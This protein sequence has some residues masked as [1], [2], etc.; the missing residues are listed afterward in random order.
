MTT[1]TP[2]RTIACPKCG[3][4]IDVS[5]L[6][7]RQIEEGLKKDFDARLA[8]EQKKYQE[9]AGE[10]EAAGRRIEEAQKRVDEAQQR[11][12]SDI[13][14]GVEQRIGAERRK[15]EE[16]IRKSLEEENSTRVKSMQEE[17]DKKSEQVKELHRTKSENERL[18]RE[19]DELKDS[20]EAELQK[21]MNDQLQDERAKIQKT[22]EDRVQMKLSEKDNLIEQMRH[23][24]QEAQRKAEQ[25]S[26]QMQG[27][28]QELAIEEWLRES[29]PLDTI[30]E[31]KKGARGADCLHIVN[32]RTR[33]NCGS[34]YYESKRTKDFQPAW[35]EKFKTDLRA[36][37]ATIGVIVTEAMP[38][39]MDRLGSNQRVWR[40]FQ[41]SRAAAPD[42]TCLNL[43]IRQCLPHQSSSF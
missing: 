20:I 2:E 14:R 31:I 13:E 9:K 1:T 28:V 18:K 42:R 38:K 33:Q 27:E 35:I 39:E 10:L 43:S 29:F 21:K 41:Q 23:Q 19:K 22:A 25:G 7:S 24:L 11:L 34:I 3:T 32:T 6:L 37:G 26:M 12:Q 40:C 17:L 36:K 30:G 5:A 16:G 15:L 8:G 4:T